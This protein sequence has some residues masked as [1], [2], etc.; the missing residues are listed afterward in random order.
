MLRYQAKSSRSTSAIQD[1]LRNRNFQ[2]DDRPRTR[3]SSQHTVFWE[4]PKVGSTAAI[5]DAMV[6]TMTEAMVPLPLNSVPV[7]PWKFKH[8]YISKIVDDELYLASFH[9]ITGPAVSIAKFEHLLGSIGLNVCAHLS[10][11]NL[12]RL[13]YSRPAWYDDCI[14]Q[15]DTVPCK[16]G[17]I[18]Q[19]PVDFNE[20][21]DS[22]QYCFTD[23]MVSIRGVEGMADWNL[24][25]STYHRLGS[26]RSP[27]D[28]AWWSMTG[29]ILRMIH[30]SDHQEFGAGEVRRRWHQGHGGDVSQRTVMHL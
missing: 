2:A 10:C 12:Q 26:C 14:P 7:L 17:N 27:D 9:H 8:S 6:D 23:Y 25:L 28:P 11:C 20:D 29:Q 19:G 4:L 21:V 22:C 3:S 1:R 24:E 30:R 13:G 16:F 15:A 5:W 18:Q